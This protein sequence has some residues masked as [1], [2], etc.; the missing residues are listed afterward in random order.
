MGFRSHAVYQCS[1]II[2]ACSSECGAS[3]VALVV[4]NLPANAGDVR[5][6][7]SIPGLGR[8]PGVGS[9]NSLQYS[10]LVNSMDRGA[11]QATVHGVSRVGHDLAINNNSSS[12][13][14]FSR[15][16]LTRAEFDRKDGKGK[17]LPGPLGPIGKKT[18]FYSITKQFTMICNIST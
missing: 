5:D 8:S 11:Q 10:C 12:N 3:Q 13:N 9:G 18:L 14:T 6:A 1:Y 2:W 17:C 4:R 16:L 15:S 7:G